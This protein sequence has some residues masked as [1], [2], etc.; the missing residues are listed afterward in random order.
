MATT[1]SSR[2]K[3]FLDARQKYHGSQGYIR[4]KCYRSLN[5]LENN[6]KHDSMTTQLQVKF[7]D[8]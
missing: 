6:M 7:F 8:K 5:Y 4:A 1:F 2:K 3:I